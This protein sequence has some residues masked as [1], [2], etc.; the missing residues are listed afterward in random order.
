MLFSQRAGG[1]SP[2]PAETIVRTALGTAVGQGLVLTKTGV[3]VA[4]GSYL[5]VAVGS[6]TMR[7]LSFDVSC[8][9]LN[10]TA[11]FAIVPFDPM[12]RE[13]FDP[14][15]TEIETANL[16]I[17]FM[18]Y[19]HC[20]TEIVNGT[21]RIDFFE[22]DQRAH[23]TPCLMMLSAV[24]GL[25]ATSPLDR[26]K[27]AA[28]HSNAPSTGATATTSQAHEY[29]V[30]LLVT[31]EWWTGSPPAGTW[32]SPME[33]GQRIGGDFEDAGFTV[34]EGFYVQT[35]AATATAAK[36]GMD[37]TQ[38]AIGVATFKAA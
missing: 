16:S 28:D 26:H 23:E 38:W 21:V 24:S 14:M 2:P 10:G 29:V 30:G 36:T 22:N 6:F 7:E 13:P 12:N 15:N 4:A 31:E 3:N 5:F 18:V 27:G 32:A 11:D 8:I 9:A 37:R 35:T 34:A 19:R 25:A 20:P 33:A 1:S 17:G